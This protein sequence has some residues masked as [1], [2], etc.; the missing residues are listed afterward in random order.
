MSD[1]WA[2]ISTDRLV[3]LIMA[4]LPVGL[5]FAPFLLSVC[6]IA[7]AVVALFVLKRTPKLVVALRPGLAQ[8]WQA[9]IKAPHF[10]ILLAYFF[11]TF[12]GIGGLEDT[13]YWLSRLRIKLPFL[14]LP[15]A[16]FFLP[17]P[18]NR[19][20][21][22]LLYF[23][24]G[25]LVLT[26]LG[27]LIN[28]LLD[29]E[30]INKLIKQGQT[31]PLPCNHVRFSLLLAFGVLIA[32]YLYFQKYYWK[33]PWEK[34]LQL[35]A[36]L[37]LFAFIHVL[38][39]RSGIV[40]VYATLFLL[41]IRYIFK[42]GRWL[43]GAGVLLAMAAFPFLAY[44]TMPSLRAKVDYVKYD[45]FMY[46]HG[47]ED[48]KLSDSARWI[49]LKIGWDIFKAHPVVGTGV[50]NFKS[51]VQNHY[52]QNYPAIS[53]LERKMPHNQFLSVLGATGVLGFL[54]FLGVFLL[55]IFYQENHQH[56]L[57]LGFYLI[58]FLSFM[59][60]NTI[61]NAMGVGFFIYYLLHLLLRFTK[62]ELRVSSDKV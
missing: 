38:S 26:S 34:Y 61:E 2:L 14:I 40:V 45:L 8:R 53:P 33:W 22:G 46:Q 19:A 27:V 1:K 43:L 37:F 6:M 32:M 57:L 44:Q 7:S 54:L 24:V 55:P 59:V 10:Y 42:T 4:L 31:L 30:A 23:L 16:F 11:L 28:Y 18:S 9:F 3:L 25:L 50:G 5:L 56:W 13:S 15:L 29:F 36:A 21:D 12:W 39:V 60:E 41:V 52:E 51:A 62:P 48:A 17:R 49:S 35:G 20:L 58:I 47:H